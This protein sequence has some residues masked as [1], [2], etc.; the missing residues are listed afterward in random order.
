MNWFEIISFHHIVIF[1]LGWL[2]RSLFP[3]IKNLGKFVEKE[4]EK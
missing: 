1:G 4:N 2:A 3:L